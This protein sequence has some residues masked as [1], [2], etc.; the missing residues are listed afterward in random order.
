MLLTPL[1]RPPA[2]WDLDRSLPS[3]EGN[4]KR[5]QGGALMVLSGDG[6][7]TPHDRLAFPIVGFVLLT[8]LFSL[9]LHGK[10]SIQAERIYG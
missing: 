3:T 4:K 8:T 5:A 10:S 6:S 2:Y 9:R 7:A 1:K